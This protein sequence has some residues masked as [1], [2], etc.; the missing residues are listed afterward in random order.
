MCINKIHFSCTCCLFCQLFSEALIRP[1]PITH[2][3]ILSFIRTCTHTHFCV[4]NTRLHVRF[5]DW[6]SLANTQ[7]RCENRRRQGN[8]HPFWRHVFQFLSSVFGIEFYYLSIFMYILSMMRG[9]FIRSSFSIPVCCVLF[10][11]WL[12]GGHL[13]LPSYTPS[14]YMLDI[15]F[16]V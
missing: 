4:L 10:G 6:L 13:Q 14:G 7:R 16:V 5:A 15:W 2:T 8:Y 3:H 12:A 11:S 1:F 9:A